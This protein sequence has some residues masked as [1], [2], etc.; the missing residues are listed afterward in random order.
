[1]GISI[2]EGGDGETVACL[3]AWWLFTHQCG[4]GYTCDC[5][6]GGVGQ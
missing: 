2:V 1:M 6:C 3:R 4:C 5:R